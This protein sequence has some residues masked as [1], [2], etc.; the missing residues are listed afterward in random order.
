MGLRSYLLSLFSSKPTARDLISEGESRWWSGSPLAGVFG[1]T[2]AANMPVSI[3]TAMTSATVYACTRAIAENLGSLPGMVYK[4]SGATRKNALDSK[5]G[6]LLYE[7]PNPEM[8]SMQFIELGVTR[9]VNRGNFFAEIERDR[10]D[11]PIALWPI[12]NSRVEPMREAGSGDLFWRI[13]SDDIVYSGKPETQ[14]H[15]IP[16]RNML[17]V[18]GFGGNGIIA[19]GVVSAAREEIAL[20]FAAQQYGGSFFGKGAKMSGVVEHPGFIDDP[21][22]RK[23]FRDD[24]NRIHSGRENWNKIGVLWQGAQYKAIEVSPEDAQFLQTR[25]FEAIRI[26]QFYN[27]PPSIVQIFEDFKFATVDAMLRQFVM[28]CLRPYAVRLERAINRQVLKVNGAGGLESAFRGNYIYEL[29]LES[30]IRGDNKTQAETLEIERRNGIKNANE[31]RAYNN[32]APLPGDQGNHYVLPGGFVRLDMLGE[33]PETEPDKPGVDK[34]EM[35]EALE[36]IVG[37]KAAATGFDPIV[38]AAVEIAVDAVERINAITA[39]QVERWKGDTSKHQ[40]FVQKQVVR[41]SE[42]LLPATKLLCRGTDR[43]P[44]ARANDIASQLFSSVQQIP[45]ESVEHALTS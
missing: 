11:T 13:H 10:T 45:V 6:V 30:L 9:L 38:E 26:C 32:E 22:T 16:S 39:Q 23:L 19:P 34:D 29:L 17:N 25:A 44:V 1:S 4:T 28:L 42:A 31:W 21:D 41:L 20:D 33:E 14:Y 24:I 18:C 2:T 35:V 40:D 43:D 15:D 7:Q 37:P 27:V 8:D 36:R 3:E 12:H 5:P